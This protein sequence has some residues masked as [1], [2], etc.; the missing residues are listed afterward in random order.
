MAVVTAPRIVGAGHVEADWQA[1]PWLS[2]LPVRAAESLLDGH[3]R[4][5]VLSPHP[6]DETL[7]CGPHNRLVK[8]GGWRTRKRKDGRTEWLPPPHLDTGQARV[9]DY[10]RPERLFR[11][12]Q[13]DEKTHEPG[14]PEPNAA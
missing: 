11:P 12:P 3:R 4:L 6:D 9:N 8:P 14:G 13:D 7:A 5:L 1:S 10:H 2:A